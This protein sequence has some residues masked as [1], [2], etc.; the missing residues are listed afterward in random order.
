MDVLKIIQNLKER[1]WADHGDVLA[2]PF[3]QDETHLTY[4]L[5]DLLNRH[6]HKHKVCDGSTF[7]SETATQMAFVAG[8][9]I[10]MREADAKAEAIVS[11]RISDAVSA[12]H[13]GGIR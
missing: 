10:G 8:L 6:D 12:L 1:L 5:S 9:R 11:Q 4:Y 3:T 13:G 7:Y 2:R